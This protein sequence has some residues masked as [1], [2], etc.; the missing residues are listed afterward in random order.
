MGAYEENPLSA[1]LI[2]SCSHLRFY[3]LVHCYCRDTR[4]VPSWEQIWEQ[5]SVNRSLH[6]NCSLPLLFRIGVR[7]DPGGQID[8][9]VP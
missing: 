9:S 4:V 5:I 8:R 6:G 2:L 1:L 7:V 3:S